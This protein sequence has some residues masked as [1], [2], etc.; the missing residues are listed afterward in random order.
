MEAAITD[1]A[2]M[3]MMP[4]I[5][6]FVWLLIVKRSAEYLTTTCQ[7]GSRCVGE[8]DLTDWKYGGCYRQDNPSSFS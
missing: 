4:L 6:R 3:A 5:A 2:L 7:Y 8:G 1:M